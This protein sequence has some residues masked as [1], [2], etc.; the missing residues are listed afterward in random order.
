MAIGFVKWGCPI[1]T[2]RHHGFSI[3]NPTKS[4]S[5]D[6]DDLGYPHWENLYLFQSKIPPWPLEISRESLGKI[7]ED[8]FL[9]SRMQSEGFPLNCGGLGAWGVFTRCFGLQPR[10]GPMAGPRG[11]SDSRI[12]LVCGVHDDD[13]GW[14]PWTPKSKE[15]KDCC[16]SEYVREDYPLAESLVSRCLGDLPKP[17]MPKKKWG[18]EVWLTQSCQALPK[19]S[20]DLQSS[21]KWNNICN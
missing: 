15:N 17:K 5:S 4:W 11:H 16:N 9:F 6:L 21:S 2:P 10:E 7:W 18:N 3:L 13:H 20:K 12:C 1:G 19:T 8:E 14:D